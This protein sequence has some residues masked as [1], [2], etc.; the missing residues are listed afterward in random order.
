MAKKATKKAAPKKK[1]AT[2]KKA[3]PKKKAAKKA[4]PKKKAAAPKKA[5][6]KKAAPKKAAPKKAKVKRAPNP[7]FMKPMNIGD[8]LAAV[9]GKNP[10]PRTEVVKRVW[11]YIKKNNLQDPKTWRWA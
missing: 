11:M 2:K 10:M 1:A 6:P 7:A 4:A 3:A 8:S 9:I 5:A